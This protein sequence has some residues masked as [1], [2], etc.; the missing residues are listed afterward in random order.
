VW[1]L[2]S[3]AIRYTPAGERVEL[4]LERSDNALHLTVALPAGVSAEALPL[5]FDRF[6][7][8]SSDR[9]QG[10]PFRRSVGLGLAMARRLVEMHGGSVSA[11]S[12]GEGHGATFAIKLPVNAVCAN[13]TAEE[14]ETERY[15]GNGAGVWGKW[16]RN[17]AGLS[18]PPSSHLPA[19]Y[20]P[21]SVSRGAAA[22]ASGAGC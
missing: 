10:V 21:A 16:E 2:L 15:G 18:L 19:S 3:N 22:G 12:P 4:S 6:R 11:S 7:G 13:E 14:W 8:A 5:V 17:G 20:S 9:A 1:N